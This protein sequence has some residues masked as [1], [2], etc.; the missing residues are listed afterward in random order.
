MTVWLTGY[1]SVVNA[2]RSDLSAKQ[3]A[4]GLPKAANY[5]DAMA[6]VT[7][8][9]SIS[10]HTRKNILAFFALDKLRLQ[11]FHIKKARLPY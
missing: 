11:N 1:L 2:M 7:T 5:K 9:Y 10:E 4:Q 8:V 3:F 6:L